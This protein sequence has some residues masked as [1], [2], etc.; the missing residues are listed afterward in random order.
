[1]FFDRDGEVRDL[2][3]AAIR[4]RDAGTSPVQALRSLAYRLIEDPDPPFPL[5]CDT[6][7]FVETA[8]ASESL[9]AR[10]RQMRDDFVRAL[11]I[12]LAESADCRQDDPNAHLAANLI[13]ATWTVAFLQAHQAFTH[14]K[15]AAA[16]NRTFLALIDRGT[17]GVEAA[18]ADTPYV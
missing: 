10:A 1:M 13:A 5:F 15:D 6:E 8:L 18:L 3:F 14:T 4:D 11:A 16:A 2:A 12:T 9:K 17:A 7:L